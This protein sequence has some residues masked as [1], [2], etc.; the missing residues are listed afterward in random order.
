VP[1]NQNWNWHWIK[2]RWRRS[3]RSP[4]PLDDSDE[5]QIDDE[6]MFHFR[7][8]VDDNLAQGM[9]SEAAWSEARQRFGSLRRHADA[10]R[11]VALADYFTIQR[12]S[13]AGLLVLGALVGWL[14]V[15][16]R[17]LRSE[18]VD[19][20]PR[21][22]TGRVLD[23]TSEPIAA[24]TLLVVL[25]TWPGGN[26]LQQSFA[27]TSDSRGRFRLVKLVPAEGQF[28]VQVAA[29]KTGY[30]LTSAYQLNQQAGSRAPDPLTLKLDR[31]T[32]ITLVVNDEHGHPV[33]G[34]RMVPH[35]RQTDDG[36]NH[37]VY[38]QGSEPIH[39][40]SDAQG[41]VGL[42]CYERGDL[43]EIYL[44]LPGEDWQLYTIQIPRDG[45]VVV[46]KARQAPNHDDTRPKN[47]TT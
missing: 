33:S 40:A 11:R 37:L 38:F 8:L 4:I 27:T 36:H 45:D 3:D 47:P 34:A 5:E 9:S 21:D 17:S 19:S 46:V 18:H 31:A 20:R 10:C 25:K 29:I 7:A 44:Q 41:R 39:V 2:A 1:W 14:A 15:D 32:P 43:A 42:G 23:S 24:A 28:A 22:L 16:V 13:I 6:L 35:S 30:T 12:F 26:Y